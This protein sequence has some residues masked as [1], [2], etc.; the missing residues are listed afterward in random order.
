[1]IPNVLGAQA[2]VSTTKQSFSS[3]SDP[4]KQTGHISK[5]IFLSI[6]KYIFLRK[7]TYFPSKNVED[8]QGSSSQ[9]RKFFLQV[10][11]EQSRLTMSHALQLVLSANFLMGRSYEAWSS[12]KMPDLFMQK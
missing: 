4:K 7:Q 9:N 6:S 10:K 1:M 12:M 3:S 11:H 2:N 8:T 5:Y